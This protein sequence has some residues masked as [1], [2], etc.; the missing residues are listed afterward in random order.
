MSNMKILDSNGSVLK[1]GDYI[2]QLQNPPFDELHGRHTYHQIIEVNGFLVLSYVTSENGQVLPDGYCRRFLS[3]LYE[4]KSLLWGGA[5]HPMDD[6]IVV[7]EKSS[8]PSHL[9]RK[10]KG[11]AS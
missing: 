7:I 1:V 5:P 10:R 11:G 6:S 4:S 9:T 8:I 3:D 2:K